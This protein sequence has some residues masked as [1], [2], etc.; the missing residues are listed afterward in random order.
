MKDIKLIE[1]QDEVMRHTGFLKK[2]PHVNMS[3]ET[4]LGRCL[5]NQ[6][7]A[8]SF[9]ED[10]VPVGVLIFRNEHPELFIIGICLQN[11]VKAFYDLFFEKIKEL[12]YT[13]VRAISKLPE[14]GYMKLLKFEKLWTVYGR[15][16]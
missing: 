8:I 9:L 14:A 1:T 7:G 10:N 12:K 6:Y 15:K 3:W 16:I 5:T 4:M 13:R 11:K 2:I